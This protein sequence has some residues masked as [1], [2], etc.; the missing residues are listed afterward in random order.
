MQ[1][2]ALKNL[3]KEP[4]IWFKKSWKRDERRNNSKVEKWCGA[5]DCRSCLFA[6]SLDLI[7]K[8]YKE[9]NE[10]GCSYKDN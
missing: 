2:F 4:F 8:F 5:G 6:F 10:T 9:F 1:N 7:A 3:Q